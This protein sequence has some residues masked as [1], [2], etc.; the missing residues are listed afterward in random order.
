MA[1]RRSVVIG[2]E[3]CLVLPETKYP[4]ANLKSGRFARRKKTEH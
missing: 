1:I 2:V 4:S 3:G